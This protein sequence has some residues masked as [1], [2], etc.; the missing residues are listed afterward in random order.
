MALQLD[1]ASVPREELPSLLGA[2]V[3]AEA[4]VRLRLAE[5]PVNAP[6]AAAAAPIDS[7]RA[8]EIAAT[9]SRWPRTAARP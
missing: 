4:R 3:E 2:L 5:T 1:V 8:A 6:P 7:K 9:T